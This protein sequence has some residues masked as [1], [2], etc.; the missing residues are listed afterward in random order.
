MLELLPLKVTENCVA[1]FTAEVG[2]LLIFGSNCQKTKSQAKQKRSNM[3]KG[4]G[5]SQS[6]RPMRSNTACI[7][8]CYSKSFSH[9][10]SVCV[11]SLD[12]CFSQIFS[13]SERG[14]SQ[15]DIPAWKE[16]HSVITSCMPPQ[17]LGN[18]EGTVLC[19]CCMTY[20]GSQLLQCPGSRCR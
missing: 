12:V 6:C 20:C 16:L 8:S 9:K 14:C 17:Q 3:V 1:I 18:G 15:L 2:K 7:K 19:F 5:G 11:C 4:L 13:C 10:P